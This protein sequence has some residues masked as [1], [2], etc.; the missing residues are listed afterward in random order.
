MRA[1]RDRAQAQAHGD[2]IGGGGRQVGQVEE[3]RVGIVGARPRLAGHGVVPEPGVAPLGRARRV[4]AVPL[5]AQ[6]AR[7][8]RGVEAGELGEEA[9]PRTVAPLTMK[10]LVAV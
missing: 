9:R 2:E 4:E 3:P 6:G 7:G 5:H 1:A 10:T 8:G